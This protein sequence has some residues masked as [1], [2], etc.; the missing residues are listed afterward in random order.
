MWG[1]SGE[2]GVLGSGGGVGSLLSCYHMVLSSEAK[3]MRRII[4]HGNN[5]LPEGLIQRCITDLDYRPIKMEGLL[6]ML[7]LNNINLLTF[8][9]QYKLCAIFWL[10]LIYKLKLEVVAVTV[11]YVQSCSRRKHIVWKYALFHCQQFT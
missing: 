7:G 8:K 9:N 1:G 5:L 3:W 10:S 11:K 4:C 2:G 6:Y